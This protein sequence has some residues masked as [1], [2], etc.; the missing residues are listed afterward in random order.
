MDKETVQKIIL[1]YQTKGF[2]DLTPRD[3]S[4]DFIPYTAAGITG[5]RRCG[6]TFRTHQLAIELSSK[7]LNENIC[8]I[9][10]NDHRLINIPS[11]EL[12]LIDSAYYALFPEKRNSEEV[13]FIFDEIHRIKGWEDYILY[14]I[15]SK[16]HKVVITGSTAS[17]Q[18][19]EFASALRGKLFPY[20]LSPFSFR[21]FLRHYSIKESIRTTKECDLL[22]NYLKKYI[23]QGGFPGLLDIPGIRHSEMLRTYWDTMILRDIIE[24]HP[25]DNINVP[26]LRFFAD[27]LV[28][29]SACPM[30]VS[31][32]SENIQKAGLSFG[33]DT[34]YKF[35]AYLSDAYMVF[36]VEIYS[37]S[38]K[39]RARNYKKIY[40]A[41]WALARAVSYAESIDDTRAFEN[42]VYLELKRRGYSINYY[43]TREE[44]EV[45]FVISRNGRI[46]GLIQACYSVDKSE[47]RDR[48]FRAL[49]KSAQYLNTDNLSVITVDDEKN[50][51]VDGLKINIYPAWKWLLGK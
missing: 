16:F 46:E 9:Q 45:D 51:V 11:A 49:V 30:T 5:V 24:S 23:T 19:G 38:E 22:L 15:E 42:L 37:V 17:L 44:H 50:E 25:E 28:A 33:K 6:K 3:L 27:S 2:E 36:P 29:R 14:L 35:L 26:L 21:E 4:I 32:L 12:H 47:V 48:E 18:R 39:V 1:D 40:C 41:D 20:E 31:R 7:G 34:L 13:Y 8:R 43:K 10:F